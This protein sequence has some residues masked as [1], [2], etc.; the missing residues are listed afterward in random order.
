MKKETKWKLVLIASMILFGLL[1]I[2]TRKVA[3][4]IMSTGFLCMLR[5]LGGAIFVLLFRV[6]SGHMPDWKG[7]GKNFLLLALSGILLGVNWAML[8]QSYL[9]MDTGI[10]SLCNYMA[11]MAVILLSPIVFKEKLTWKK[12]LCVAVAFIGL[13]LVSGLLTGGLTSKEGGNLGIGFAYGL[14]GAACYTMMYVLN[15]KMKGVSGYDRSIVQLFF[16]GLVMIPYILFFEG[17]F[18]PVQ[19]NTSVI[20]WT[21]VIVVIQTGLV[22]SMYY[23]CIEYVSAQTT[24][25]FAYIDPVMTVTLGILVLG[26]SPNVVKIIG[27]VLIIGAAVMSE[28]VDGLGKKPKEVA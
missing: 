20:I 9:Y 5:G 26:E 28:I 15:K 22:Y 3:D 21:L 17:G 2:T 13:I 16:A 1:A 11:P 8:F 12:G 14:T 25:I 24:S 19:W 23:G 7:M 4:P 18:K 10:G 6:L 27:A